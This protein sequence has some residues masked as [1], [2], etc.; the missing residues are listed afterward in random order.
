[1]T[2]NPASRSSRATTL[3]P[4]SCPSMP[5][6]AI[7]T[8]IG[9]E[10]R[11]SSLE[12]PADARPETPDPRPSEVA[13]VAVLPEDVAQRVHDLAGRR[14]GVDRLQDGRHQVGSPEG[15]LADRLQRPQVPFA[16]ALAQ[17]GQAS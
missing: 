3:A 8:R 2:S 4:R 10:S 7:T 9:L 17:L 14:V 11:V 15:R 13:R 1:M 5:A 12:S 6:F 16:A